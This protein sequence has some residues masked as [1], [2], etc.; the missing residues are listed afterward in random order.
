MDNKRRKFIKS[1][2]AVGGE[3][4]LLLVTLQRQHMQ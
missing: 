4:H 2:L 1:G 3:P